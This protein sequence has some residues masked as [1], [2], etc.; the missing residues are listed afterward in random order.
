MKN[1]LYRRKQVKG[2]MMKKKLEGRPGRIAKPAKRIYDDLRQIRL[3][4]RF[5]SVVPF[6]SLIIHCVV[7]L[8]SASLTR[9]MLKPNNLG[10]YL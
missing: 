6:W 4:C 8:I 1:K 2:Q 5:S 3:L 7:R 9:C 10:A